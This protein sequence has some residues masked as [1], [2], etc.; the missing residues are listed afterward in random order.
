MG[1]GGSGFFS[2][3]ECVVVVYVEGYGGIGGVGVVV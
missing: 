2:I 3:L 1:E